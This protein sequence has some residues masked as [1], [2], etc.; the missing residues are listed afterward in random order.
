MNIKT[1]R[2]G[3]P[4]RNLDQAVLNSIKTNYEYEK[5]TICTLLSNQSA[6]LL[7]VLSQQPQQPLHL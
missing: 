7:S 4:S 6:C 3:L 2:E 1:A 5:I